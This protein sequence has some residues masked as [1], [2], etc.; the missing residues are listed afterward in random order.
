MN[1]TPSSTGRCV[2]CGTVLS[3]AV[4]EGLC[5]R[6]LTRA[7]FVEGA[8]PLAEDPP[9][10]PGPVQRIGG[11]EL[12]EPIGRGGMGVVYRARQISL[13]REVALK[14]LLNP[15]FASPDELA[16]FRAEAAS[17]AV[18]QHPNIV[19]VHE[20]GDEA[21]C[22]FF[23]MDFVPGKNLATLTREGPLPARM[24]AELALKIAGATQH[25]HERGILHRDLK[26]SNVLVDASGDPH[27]TDFGLS[28]K[29]AA[30]PASSGGSPAD[31][32][33]SPPLTL[34]GHVIGTPGYM[35]PEQAA[36]RRDIGPAADVYSLGALLYHL[37]T[38]RAPFVGETPMEV[39]RQVEEQEPVSAR[40]LNPLVP[41]DLE[42]ICHKCL[43]KEPQRRY[44][45]AQELRE[46]LR[47]FLAGEAI[48]ARP[49]GPVE[50]TC[51]WCRRRP[52]ITGLLAL[53]SALLLAVIAVT[54][55]AWV[56]LEAAQRLVLRKDYVA[57]LRLV[58]RA[59]QENN[60]GQAGALLDRWRPRG[61]AGSRFG[62]ARR[63]EDLR[64]FEWGFFADLCRGDELRI[65][66]Q[67]PGHALRVAFSPRGDR[68]AGASA[69]GEVRL[70]EAETGRLLGAA[71]HGKRVMALAF[72]PDDRFLATGGDDFRLALWD[73]RTL[74]PLASPPPLSSALVTA[75]FA[76]DGSSLVAVARQECVIWD[77]ARNLATQRAA[78]APSTWFY[79]ALAPDLRTVALP[80][81]EARG[82]ELWTVPPRVRRGAVGGLGVA[83]AFS[84]DGRLLA[85]G[86]LSGQLRVWGADDLHEVASIPTRGG[87]IG[88]L[89]WSPDGKRLASGGHDAFLRL[90]QFPGG[91][92]VGTYRGHRGFIFGAAFSPDGRRVATASTDGTVRLWDAEHGPAPPAN[93]VRKDWGLLLPRGRALPILTHGADSETHWIEPR[94]LTLVPIPLPA[95]LRGTNTIV[96]VTDDG[97]LVLGPDAAVRRF[98]R[99]GR[100]VAPAVRLPHWPVF[101][102]LASPD[103][104]WLTWKESPDEIA[105]YKLW[106]IGPTNAAEDLGP[107]RTEWLMHAFSNDSRHLAMITPGGELLVRD[108]YRRRHR[109]GIRSAHGTPTA[110]SFS[111]DDRQL[112]ASWQDGMVSVWTEARWDKPP[113]PLVAGTE[114]VW[115]VAFSPDGRR[116]AGGG[117]DG[118][119]FLWDVSTGQLVAKLK[120]PANTVVLGVGF[121]EAGDTLFASTP[122]SVCI[123]RTRP[124]EL[125]A[126]GP[127]GDK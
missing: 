127:A 93:P 69:D 57:D 74:R 59:I 56:R 2:H 102:P 18:L 52:A 120:A 101:R 39:L 15:A 82:V 20:V 36:A 16:R 28:K 86:E 5:P 96:R 38:G 71:K 116:V 103:G 60:L 115:C 31:T 90:W 54:V 46:D 114:A 26:P 75:A 27:V 76:R 70:W 68:V 50:R 117:D 1:E 110:L 87:G 61:Q 58:D 126:P 85:T 98:D 53:S 8:E 12:I 79:G 9:G 40:L 32:G 99:A 3:V 10:L 84:G 109:R 88:A 108:L 6:C 81:P 44:P 45:S 4:A 83:A 25:A 92:L 14:V 19:A 80:M 30:M 118:D 55:S 24:A 17:A 23:S 11:Y 113:S 35:S 65:L 89:A 34:T 77:L 66:G 41:R 47:R 13:G 7:V 94:Q 51:R 121:S 105:S 95:E 78:I 100:P 21:G 125:E 112:V 29:L 111:R 72:S 104:R 97:F 122:Q 43:A 63:D 91:G 67:Y 64:G 107:R 22:L 49:A 42:V 37:L 33:P 62:F 48:R 124:T 123:W 106:E 73:A 119:V